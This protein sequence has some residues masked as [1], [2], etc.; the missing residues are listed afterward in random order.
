MIGAGIVGIPYAYSQLG[1]P[2]ALVVTVIMVWC[3][4]NSCR[5]YFKTMDILNGLQSLGE[6]G[7]KLLGRKAIFITN[8]FV[9]TNCIGSITA[10]Y[11]IFGVIMSQLYTEFTED[12]TSI[13]A[14]ITFYKFVFFAINLPPIMKRTLGELKIISYLLVCSIVV[15]VSFFIM[16]LYKYGTS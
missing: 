9:M 4:M 2:L 5:L 16:L 3:T 12:S 7:Y 11:N 6:I 15:L 14:N 8:G 10:Y 1:V 13:L